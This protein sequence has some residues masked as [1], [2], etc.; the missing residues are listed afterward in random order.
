MD[1]QVLINEVS[2]LL[3]EKRAVYFIGAGISK[4]SNFKSWLELLN[5]MQSD[6]GIEISDK[7]DLP[8]MAQFIVNNSL[9]NKGRLLNKIVECYTATDNNN[10]N[11][12]HNALITTSI[13]TIWTTNY[14]TLIEQAFGDSAIVVRRCDRDLLPT[15]PMNS[16]IEI[17]KM[18]GSVDSPL[19]ENIIITKEDYE[20]YSIT[21]PLTTERLRSDLLSKSFVFIG[22]SYRDPNIKAIMTE[23]RHLCN[24][25]MTPHYMILEEEKDDNSIKLQKLWVKDLMRFGIN[26]Y[27]YE[28]GKHHELNSIMNEIARKSKGKAVFVTG[29]HKLNDDN[30]CNELGKKLSEIEDLILVYG[31]SEGVGSQVVK[32]FIEQ[33]VMNKK[34]IQNRLK[35]YANPYANNK[36]WDN[37]DEYLVQLKKF[38]TLLMRETQVMIVFDGGKGTKLEV[39]LAKELGTIIIP[40]IRKNNTE[41]ISSLIVDESILCNIKKYSKEYYNKIKSKDIV[42][43]ED[44]ISC[45]KEILC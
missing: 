36:E 25:R 4:P 43:I 44:L 11:D 28:H 13:D 16:K 3:Y 21:H 10:I 12:Y 37:K 30:M 35:I 45:V 18:H 17:I 9:D 22:Y 40:V 19:P 31:Q 38:R 26:T 2:K 6:I 34:E 27:M 33:G 14:D 7:D 39:E 8:E 24:R 29:S 23:V 41:F 20:D 1:K 15:T 42:S 32:S 5:T